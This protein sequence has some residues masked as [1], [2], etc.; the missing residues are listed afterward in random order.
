MGRL[1]ARHREIASLTDLALTSVWETLAEVC[2]CVGKPFLFVFIVSHPYS[3]ALVSV[4]EKV[5]KVDM[6]LSVLYV[7]CQSCEEKGIS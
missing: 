1:S 5:I 7:F 2:N 3:P 4:K 6:A